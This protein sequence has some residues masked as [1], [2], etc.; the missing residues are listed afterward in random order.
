MFLVANFISVAIGSGNSTFCNQTCG[1]KSVSYPFGFSDGCEIRLN[2][3]YRDD[4]EVAGFQ[5]LN[6]TSDN[7]IIH[8]PRQCNRKVDQMKRL[9]SRN[10]AVSKQNALLLQNCSSS[11]SNCTIP[12]DL[13]ENRFKLQGIQGCNHDPRYGNMSCYLA[14]TKG[15]GM[16][17]YD[18]ISSSHCGLLVSSTVVNSANDDLEI[19]LEF[20]T[21]QL[22]WWLPGACN[23]SANANCSNV[24][25]ANG[26]SG[27]RC[28]CQDGFIGDGFA[29]GSRC[30]RG[31]F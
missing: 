12:T 27:Y 7:I 4:V 11:Q 3:S 31:M 25:V 20:Q 18:N 26:S 2:C 13:I 10:Y 24:T 9:F 21:I 17:T 8:T 15:N 1:N 19:S 16:L 22:D 6:V 23:C 29:Q 30:Y 28:S 5:V 14:A